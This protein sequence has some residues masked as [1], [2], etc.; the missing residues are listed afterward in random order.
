MGDAE[1]QPDLAGQGRGFCD[2]L[3]RRAAGEAAR[4]GPQG[5][6]AVSEIPG[7]H[8][9]ARPERGGACGER[10][11][12]ADLPGRGD[13]ARGT[14]RGGGPGVRDAATGAQPAQP[15]RARGIQATTDR[16]GGGTGA[17]GFGFE[18]PGVGGA[19]LRISKC[20]FWR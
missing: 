16:P 6:A 4:R 14:E 10:P 20:P 3:L 19:D 17:R 2:R 8:D 5:P 12:Q 7:W 13:D 15:D 11:G 18:T 9:Q 1:D